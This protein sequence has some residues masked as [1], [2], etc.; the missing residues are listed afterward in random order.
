MRELIKRLLSLN[1]ALV[2][3]LTA[4]VIPAS[5]ADEELPEKWLRVDGVYYDWDVSSSGTG[6][7]YYAGSGL[8]RL[9][10]YNGG[11]IAT[12]Q[13][14]L[15]L[16]GIGTITGK[17]EMPAI[18]CDGAVCFSTGIN[19]AITLTGGKDA[20][21]ISCD[22]LDIGMD[23]ATYT[24]ASG[25]A[26]VPAVDC[27]KLE[28]SGLSA[29]A[30]IKAGTS[31][32]TATAVS[33]YQK[34]AYFFL[35][36]D[37]YRLTFMDGSTTVGTTDV[38]WASSVSLPFP[39]VQKE[40]CLLVGW[41]TSAGEAYDNGALIYNIG[42]REQINGDTTYY[43]KWTEKVD[44][45]VLLYNEWVD[46]SYDSCVE[47]AVLTLDDAHGF[48]NSGYKLAGWYLIGDAEKTPVTALVPGDRYATIWEPLQVNYHLYNGETLTFATNKNLSNT[49]LKQG[50]PTIPDGA[51][52]AG[53]NSAADGSG[54]WYY[55]DSGLY[56]YD[57]K[58]DMDLYSQYLE[59]SEEKVLLYLDGTNHWSWQLPEYQGYPLNTEVQLPDK[60]GN[61]AVFAWI[62]CENHVVYQPGETYTFAEHLTLIPA[63]SH[64]YL[65]QDSIAHLRCEVL[66]ALYWPRDFGGWATGGH[67]AYLS[68]GGSSTT[69]GIGVFQD[70]GAVSDSDL[71]LYD[72]KSFSHE[73]KGFAG[74][75]T[76]A[77]GSGLS[78]SAG[79]NV[80]LGWKFDP[81]VLYA[82]WKDIL[83]PELTPQSKTYNGS[84]QGFALAGGYTITYQQ[85]GV[86]VEPK[87]AGQYDVVISKAETETTLSYQQT[88]KNGL[89]ILPAELTVTVNS[90]TAYVGGALPE[91]TYTVSGWQGT[92]SWVTAPKLTCAAE[93]TSA[94][95]TYTI[96][97]SDADAGSN[98]TI[99][100]VDGLLTVSRRQVARD[101]RIITFT[102][103]GGTTA[104]VTTDKN[105]VVT[106]I[107]VKIS[108]LAAQNGTVA[109]V[110]AELAAYSGEEIRIEV[111]AG[112]AKIGLP[113]SNMH[114]GIVAVIVCADGTEEVVRQSADTENGLVFYLEADAT[115][116]V[117]DNSKSFVDVPDGYAFE[118]EI[119]FVS[120]R[121]LFNGT[122]ESTFSSTA[123]A[124]R[125][126]LMTVLARLDGVD[127]KTIENGMA[128]AVSA[129]IS[130]GSDADKPISRQQLA[131]MLWRYAGCPEANS[132]LEC[133]DVD[134]V[135][136]YAKVALAWAMEN[137]ILN[138]YSDG[139]LAPR[140]TASR[141]HIAAMIARYCNVLF[142]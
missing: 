95:A 14:K 51:L 138:G 77:D 24:I 38:K 90:K 46:A 54:A 72:G 19:T 119:N 98:Y 93:S 30:T 105:G 126:Q 120:A 71:L 102:A 83:T 1:L 91:Y 18:K 10:N 112:G 69:G 63:Y 2:L 81:E 9:N 140:N 131:T 70:F 142:G 111:P 64:I 53:W 123:S 36:Q 86:A 124:T 26:D 43:A 110:P 117:I 100:Y 103:D 22:T 74:W 27:N 101:S 60:L 87:D 5:A 42:S 129:G 56:G 132:S 107:A 12:N 115:V 23:C 73:E 130:D 52:F 76:R 66:E 3:A 97:A 116:K 57:L 128:W 47:T 121:G 62:G 39:E 6:W 58:A 34:Q 40:D 29:T 85:E 68:N 79:E 4:T 84:V 108:T 94:A 133:A 48:E 28:F 25:G 89:T 134:Q 88:V 127:A 104:T 44:G 8:V 113:V 137:G 99:K 16:S 61:D 50:D 78:Y 136:D 49:R 33:A 41:Q 106:D 59:N 82:V 118:K 109:A 55:C 37:S 13:E 92:D 11:S 80:G 125:G 7:Q 20:S 114:S 135:S 15:A 32:A 141:A 17:E 31:A 45:S 35:A 122:T 96:I 75:N 139:R 65:N 67:V 21:A